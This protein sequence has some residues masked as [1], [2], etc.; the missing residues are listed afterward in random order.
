METN[1]RRH[2]RTSSLPMSPRR[3][4]RRKNDHR[5]R[6]ASDHRFK[7]HRSSAESRRNVVHPEMPS[8]PLRTSHSS[9]TQHHSLFPP[10]SY[11]N[12]YS[13]SVE[14]DGAANG[15]DWVHPSHHHHHAYNPPPRV[16][17]SYWRRTQPGI[18][19]PFRPMPLHPPHFLTGY[20]GP[21]YMTG[22]PPSPMYGGESRSPFTLRGQY[23]GGYG[24]P[25]WY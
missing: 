19:N 18:P 12:S 10:A 17:Q 4:T 22:Q 14:D 11:N 9:H 1:R 20:Q 15:Y 24:R 3:G 6:H 25:R 5:P 2:S 8:Q 23:D 7:P 13:R 21:P 16:P